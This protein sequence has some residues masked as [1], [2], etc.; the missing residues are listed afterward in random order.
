MVI[1]TFITIHYLEFAPPQK[2]LWVFLQF[3]VSKEQQN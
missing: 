1:C 3:R 2:E